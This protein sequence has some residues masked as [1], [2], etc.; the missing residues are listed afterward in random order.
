[1]V[2][3]ETGQRLPF[4]PV[5]VHPQGVVMVGQP[6]QFDPLNRPGL[7]RHRLKNIMETT[8]RS[9]YLQL[10]NPSAAEAAMLMPGH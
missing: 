1:M 8:I 4:Y 5:A 3:A 10:E 9:M 6:V 2:Y 7:E